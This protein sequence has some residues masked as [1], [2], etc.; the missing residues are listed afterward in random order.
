MYESHHVRRIISLLNHLSS[1]ERSTTDLAQLMA[2]EAPDAEV[3][4]RQI[5]RDL[6]ALEHAGVPLQS[7]RNGTYVRWTIPREYRMLAP[8]RP[9]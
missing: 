8:H 5:Q 6:K 2:Q 7:I 4:I 1:G 9:A 3:T